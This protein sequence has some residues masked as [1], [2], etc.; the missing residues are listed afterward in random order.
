MGL[1]QVQQ[2]TGNGMKFKLAIGKTF[3]LHDYFNLRMSAGA[4]YVERRTLGVITGVT[5][6]LLEAG[7][8]FYF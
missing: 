6:G 2:D 4:A 5:I 7:A 1:S 3:F 8:V